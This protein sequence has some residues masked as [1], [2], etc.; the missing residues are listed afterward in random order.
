MEVCTPCSVVKHYFISAG[1][2]ARTAPTL[3][4]HSYMCEC[5]RTTKS[6]HSRDSSTGGKHYF[7]KGSSVKS[8]T[9]GQ[10]D[11]DTPLWLVFREERAPESGVE[12]SYPPALDCSAYECIQMEHIKKRI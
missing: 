5:V 7:L 9:L 10:R 1:G 2:M 4:S 8:K 12:H 6:S 11:S 3:E